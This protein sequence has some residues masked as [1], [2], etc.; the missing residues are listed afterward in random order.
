LTLLVER[1]TNY[2]LSGD[3]ASTVNARIKRDFEMREKV[4]AGI[5]KINSVAP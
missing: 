1:E 5:G 4:Q 2:W 3:G